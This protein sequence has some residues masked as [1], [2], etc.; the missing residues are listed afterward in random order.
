MSARTI[1]LVFAVLALAAGCGRA[2]E[3]EASA[4]A[5]ASS[6]TAAPASHVDGKNFKLDANGVGDCKAGGDCVLTLRLEAVGDYHINKEYPYKFKAEGS[7]V[8]FQGTDAAGKN[9][10]SKGAGDFTLEGEKVGTMKVK[11]K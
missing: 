5:S 11:F 4:A 10:F 7:G 1:R 9:V 2:T 8:E 3:A 6:S